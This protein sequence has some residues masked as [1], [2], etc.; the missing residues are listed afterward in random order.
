M[1]FIAAEG[2][3]ESWYRSYVEGFDTD[4]TGVKA[5][6]LAFGQPIKDVEAAWRRWLGEKG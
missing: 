6:E 5:I 2:H 4:P 1:R 3:L